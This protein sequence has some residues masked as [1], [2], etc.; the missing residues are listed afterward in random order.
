MSPLRRNK[1][2]SLI[3]KAS[4]AIDFFTDIRTTGPG[5]RILAQKRRNRE[6]NTTSCS[7]RLFQR[8]FTQNQLQQIFIA[9]TTGK[10]D[11]GARFL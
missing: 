8:N 6:M 9:L 7:F 1:P 4:L 10:V 5:A 2:L 11:F 3:E